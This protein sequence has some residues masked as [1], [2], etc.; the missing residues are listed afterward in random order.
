MSLPSFFPILVAT[1]LAFGGAA[2]LAQSQQYREQ[3]VLDPATGTWG[4]LPEPPPDPPTDELGRARTLLAEGNWRGA[5]RLLKR[6]LEENGDH[7]RYLEGVFLY[8]ESYFER[9]WYWE[10]YEQ[11]EI[12]AEQGSGELFQLALRRETDVARAFLAGKK[13][14]VLRIFWIVAY[15]DGIKILDR[16]WERTPGTRLGEIALKLKADYFFNTGE[17]QSAQDEYVNLAREYPAGRFTRFAALRAAEAAAAAFPGIAYDERPLLNAQER[18]QEVLRVYPEY[19]QQQ[20][21]EERLSGIRSQR[22]EKDLYVA[23]WYERTGR[24]GAAEFYY[25][26][27]LADWPE[28]LAAAE[29]E[30]RLRGL[31]FESV[32]TGGAP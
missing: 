2:A 8:G 20:R 12:V 10:A 31:G 22:A 17:L 15:D 21:V 30:S 4:E 24:R 5:N 9:G 28:T 1:T 7:D 26:Q 27:I 18:Y 32:E 16:V 25:R 3:E 29:A 6:W 23:K 14:R 11:Y 13:R 19:A